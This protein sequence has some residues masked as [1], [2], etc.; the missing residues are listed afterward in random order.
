[1]HMQR[2]PI[3]QRMSGWPHQLAGQQYC[4]HGKRE[5]RQPIRAISRDRLSSETS[6]M[7][8]K[9]IK[10]VSRR[11]SLKANC[12]KQQQ[13][14]RVRACAGEVWRDTSSV[15]CARVVELHV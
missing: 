4:G 12:Q 14:C 2:T 3:P 8:A 9:A 13:S 7:E 10:Y 6:E 11:Q 1:M 5:R 15:V